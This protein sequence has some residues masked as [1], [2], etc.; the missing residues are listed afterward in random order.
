ML[1]PLFKSFASSLQFLAWLAFMLFGFFG[2]ISF[3]RES[4]KSRTRLSSPDRKSSSRSPALHNESRVEAS[5]NTQPSNLNAARDQ[6][7]TN[8]AA[9]ASAK[10]F[11]NRTI[12]GLS[13]LPGN[14]AIQIHVV[15][16]SGKGSLQMNAEC[17]D[18]EELK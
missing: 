3:V 9:T 17:D 4:M 10:S 15:Q 18:S 7:A 14:E 11:D 12:E 8:S 13:G 5:A 16:D 1:P 2:L 6:A